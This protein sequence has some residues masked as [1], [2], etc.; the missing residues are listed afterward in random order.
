MANTRNGVTFWNHS[1]RV[2]Q[3][4]D[5]DRCSVG[6]WSE[7]GRA[8]ALAALAQHPLGRMLVCDEYQGRGVQFMGWVDR[9][10]I[11]TVPGTAA[12]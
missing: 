6:S 4:F 7:R 11:D 12:A 9:V 5:A 2:Y 3:V 10:V 8:H 1:T